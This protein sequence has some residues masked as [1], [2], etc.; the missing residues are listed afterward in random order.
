MLDRPKEPF[1][2]AQHIVGCDS[3]LFCDGLTHP[4]CHAVHSHLKLDR[5]ESYSQQL[6]GHGLVRVPV[7]EA[8]PIAAQLGPVEWVPQDPSKWG[9]EDV[10]IPSLSGN[11][12]KACV[13]AH[14]ARVEG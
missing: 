12:S 5:R 4:R 8:C 10:T 7:L 13:H 14:N 2:T 6:A 1:Y 3:F 9:L 11:R